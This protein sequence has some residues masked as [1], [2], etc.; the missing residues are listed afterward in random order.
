MD[1]VVDAEFRNTQRSLTI[2]AVMDTGALPVWIYEK[3]FRRLG[4]KLTEDMNGARDAGGDGCM[5][6]EKN[7]SISRS[8]AADFMSRKFG[9]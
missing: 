1:V 7:K 9:L 5:S 8:R 2:P 4:G 6:K 3:L